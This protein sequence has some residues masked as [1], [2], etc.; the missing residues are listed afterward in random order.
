MLDHR[1]LTNTRHPMKLLALG[2]AGPLAGAAHAA[3]ACDGP[4]ALIAHTAEEAANP[5]SG[6]VTTP[7]VHGVVEP[8]VCAL[9]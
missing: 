4:A 7:L 5:V 9:R 2:L 1:A 8:A 3:P 6:P